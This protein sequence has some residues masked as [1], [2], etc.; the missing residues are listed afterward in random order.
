MSYYFLFHMNNLNQS[1]E[2]FLKLSMIM[3]LIRNILQTL[4]NGIQLIN[5]LYS[6]ASSFTCST[7]SMA[8]SSPIMASMARLIWARPPG[9]LANRDNALRCVFL[10]KRRKYFSVRSASSLISSARLAFC[11]G[12]SLANSVKVRFTDS[13]SASTMIG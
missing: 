3:M 8:L 11:S 13:A 1:L 5:D 7:P 2:F 12:G 4:L 9:V 10:E 6:S